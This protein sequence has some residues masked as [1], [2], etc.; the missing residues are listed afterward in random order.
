MEL[1][2]PLFANSGL[3]A[4][5]ALGELM[6]LSYGLRPS[7]RF[8]GTTHATLADSCLIMASDNC[9]SFPSHLM[10]LFPGTVTGEWRFHAAEYVPVPVNGSNLE[11]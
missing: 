10:P 9:F 11:T 5:P 7:P 3:K 1:N 8:S 6:L 4:I 2:K